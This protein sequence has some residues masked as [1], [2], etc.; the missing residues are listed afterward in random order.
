MGR[1]ATAFASTRIHST[2]EQKRRRSTSSP[3]SLRHTCPMVSTHQSLTP[4]RNSYSRHGRSMHSESPMTCSPNIASSSSAKPSF[5]VWWYPTATA[6]TCRCLGISS[7]R[8]TTSSLTMLPSR[9]GPRA[10]LEVG[11]TPSP[12][13]ASNDTA[14]RREELIDTSGLTWK[15]SPEKRSNCL[16]DG[17]KLVPQWHPK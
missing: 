10:T 7:A 14:Q 5:W 9:H 6:V 11:G 15:A 3:A 12:P 1:L 13:V 16:R 2:Y 17:L 8:S 4:L